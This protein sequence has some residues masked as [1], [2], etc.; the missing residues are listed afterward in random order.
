[1]RIVS[2]IY[3]GRR[4][5]TPKSKDIRPTSDKVR[6]ALFNA[7]GSL[8]A[9]HNA[10]V[11]DG[12]CGTGA[13]GLEALSRSAA[14]CV[15]IDKNSE[16]LSLAKE[17]ASQLGA[18]DCCAFKRDDTSK[19]TPNNEAPYDLIFLDPPYNKDLISQSLTALHTG[20]WLSDTAIIICESEKNWSYTGQE[21]DIRSEKI[22]GETKITILG[23]Q[24]RPNKVEPVG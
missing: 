13:L 18:D 11:L 3:G 1:M 22:Y 14:F 10:R 7:L 19:L 12:F 24:E 21:F 6:G 9:L 20:E 2:G 17:N 15:F 5:M 23:S 16:S 8:D 4:L